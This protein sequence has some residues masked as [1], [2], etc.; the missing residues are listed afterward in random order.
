MTKV[1]SQK[2]PV[3][4]Y[5]AKAPQAGAGTATLWQSMMAMTTAV[6]H[7]PEP[8]PAKPVPNAAMPQDMPT[9]PGEMKD[10]GSFA[11]A[12]TEAVRPVI[13]GHGGVATLFRLQVEETSSSVHHPQTSNSDR[14]GMEKLPTSAQDQRG[15]IYPQRLMPEGYLSEVQTDVETGPA[16]AQNPESQSQGN[17][18]ATN[19][20]GSCKAKAV[21]AQGS[22]P[23]ESGHPGDIRA[24]AGSLAFAAASAAS[25]DEGGDVSTSGG[26]PA[27]E[28]GDPAEWL[29]KNSLM[30]EKQGNLQIWVRDYRL[31]KRTETALVDHLQRTARESGRRIT[32]ITLNGRTLWRGGIE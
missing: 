4:D 25:E 30:V 12:T 29:R 16:K 14:N 21:S 6:T 18:V 19:E 2:S 15:F 3:G 10:R 9:N 26:A 8:S 1:V 11:T 27:I 31:D 7:Q 23:S 20:A 22:A 28:G 17:F 5:A 32:S 13:Q 24:S